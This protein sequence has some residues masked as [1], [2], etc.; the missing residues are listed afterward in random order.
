MKHRNIIRTI[1]AAVALVA[2]GACADTETAG[3]YMWTYRI[4]GGIA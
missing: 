4:N 3:G 2:F 1:F